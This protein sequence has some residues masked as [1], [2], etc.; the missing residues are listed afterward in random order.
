MNE[1]DRRA[2]AVICV[3]ERDAVSVSSSRLDA[4]QDLPSDL[5]S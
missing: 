1:H 3:T 5:G 2:S 4:P